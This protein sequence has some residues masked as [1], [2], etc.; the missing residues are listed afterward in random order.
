MRIST[1]G[2]YGLLIMLY[3][4]KEYE[5]DKYISLKEIS[6]KENISL[7]YLEKIMLNFKNTNYFKS[8][9][10]SEGGYKLS[11][12]PESYT[13]KDIL[14]KAEGSMDITSCVNNNFNCEKKDKCLSINLLRDLNNL[15]SN[16]LESK[17]LKDLIEGK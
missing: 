7:K 15:I 13:I 6:E 10:G 12:P 5:N 11:M 17:T 14:E 3:L 2:R 8:S 9:R 16:Y 4:A 1:K